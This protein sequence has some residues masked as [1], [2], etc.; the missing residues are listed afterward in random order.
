MKLKFLQWNIWYKENPDNIIQ[1]IQNSAADIVTAQ[2]LIQNSK[3][4]VDTAQYIADRLGF[5]YFY[6]TA[7][8]W[9]NRE[10]KKAQGNAIFSR[11]PI[12]KSDCV[13]L[14]K[15]KHNPTNALEEG[16][17]YLEVLFDIHGKK[18]TIGTTHLSLTPHFKITNQR[19]KEINNLI[20]VIKNKKSDYILGADLNVVPG[21][22]TIKQLEKYLKSAG[23]DYGENTF[24]NQAFDY[25]GMFQVKGLEERLDYV[26]ATDDIRVIG[27]QVFPTKYSDHLPILVEIEL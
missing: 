7:D 11:F 20:G 12:V 27:A 3:T 13:Y 2:E 10:E 26:F 24:A 18:L 14:Q 16:R 8:T 15:P 21:S 25:R 9:D 19:K 4:N 17:V 6:Q 23:P 5:N 1:E 22:Y